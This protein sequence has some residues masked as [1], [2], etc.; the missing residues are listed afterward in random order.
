MRNHTDGSRVPQAHRRN[1]TRLRPGGRPGEGDHATG[2]STT[3]RASV[4][5]RAGILTGLVALCAMALPAVAAAATGGIGGTVTSAET[6]KPIENVEAC[7]YET[8][9]EVQVKCATT[10]ANGTYGILGLNDGSYKVRF[11]ATGYTT[12]WFHGQ[13]NWFAGETVE[14]TGSATTPAINAELEEAGVGTVKGQVTNA[15]N[16]QGAGGVEACAVG[17]ET[18]RCTETNSNGEYTL[19]S[20]SPGSYT[21]YFSP[22]EACEEEQGEKLRCQPKSNYIGKSAETKAKANKTEVVN[23]ALQPG[24]EISGTVTNAS[25]THPAIAKIGVCAYKTKG[26]SETFSSCGYTNS[27]GQYTVSGLESGSYKLEFYGRICTIIKKGEEECPE[28]YVTQ[29]YRGQPSRKKGETVSATA[30]SV[31][32][33]INESLHEAF[34]TTPASTAAPALTGKAILG[35][36]LSCSQGTWSHE[37]TYLTYQWLRNGT[38]ISG[39]TGTTYT[40]QTADLGNSI[41]CSVTAGNGAGAASV[42]SNAV[43]VPKPLVTTGGSATVKGNV[44]MLKLTCTGGGPCAGTLKLV[45]R[46]RQGKRTTNVTVGTARFSIALTKSATVRVRLT[47]RG[48]SLLGKA[49]KRGLKVTL[50]GGNVKSRTLVLK[51]AKGKK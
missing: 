23:I 15:S 6:T 34:P 44:A 46:V 12:Q 18:Y 9:T 36:T 20:L 7:A 30:G 25:I 49:G 10:I 8:T 14:V 11:K 37:P 1:N 48:R 16:G 40:L 2:R 41:T 39:Q 26:S 32:S 17:S 51:A 42:T 35:Q 3:G 22:A 33:G 47:A 27:S 21:I 5:V 29:Y 31:T 38:V 43:A 28:V 24:G 19:S 45:A 4:L 50:S 13:A